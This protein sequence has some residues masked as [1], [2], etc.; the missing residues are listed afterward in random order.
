MFLFL[1]L[2]SF[3]CYAWLS[4]EKKWKLGNSKLIVVGL[5][6]ISTIDLLSDNRK[7]FVYELLFLN[8]VIY[9]RI[10]LS[11]LSLYAGWNSLSKIN[12]SRI[13]VLLKSQELYSVNCL[14]I[15]MSCLTSFGRLFME[16]PI[17]W[18]YYIH[19]VPNVSKIEDKNRRHNYQFNRKYINNASDRRLF[20]KRIQSFTHVECVKI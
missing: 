14:N 1:V 11:K 8:A 6:C 19:M 12:T 5:G 9:R 17:L 20:G 10:F 3:Y 16:T 2:E 4:Y 18:K 13:K 15:F 7:Y